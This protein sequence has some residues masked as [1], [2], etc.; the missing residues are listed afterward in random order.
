MANIRNITFLLGIGKHIILDAHNKMG[1][2]VTHKDI[3]FVLEYRYWL[4]NH[5]VKGETENMN[6]DSFFHIF[7]LPLTL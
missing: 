5:P 3:H 6:I 7:V 1:L 4:I 2:S